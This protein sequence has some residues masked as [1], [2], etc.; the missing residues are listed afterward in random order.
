MTTLKRLG[1]HGHQSS[2][3]ITQTVA[4]IKFFSVL[5]GQD[6]S[7]CRQNEKNIYITHGNTYDLLDI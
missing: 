7:S 6:V 3:P 5:I 2:L 4:T 1:C